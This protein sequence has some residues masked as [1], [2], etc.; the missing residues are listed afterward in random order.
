MRSSTPAKLNRINANPAPCGGLDLATFATDLRNLLDVAAG[1]RVLNRVR[2][3]NAASEEP[4]P[5]RTDADACRGDVA[6]LGGRIRE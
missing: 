1:V 5:A 6:G 3:G 2:V 4:R